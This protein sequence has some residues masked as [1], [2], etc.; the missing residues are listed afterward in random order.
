[1]GRSPEEIF[2]FTPITLVP[3]V[4]QGKVRSMAQTIKR[5]SLL[6]KTKVDYQLDQDGNPINDYAINHVQGCSHGCMYPCYAYL[7]AKRFG[8][9]GSYEEWCRPKLVENA[10]DLL[11]SELL[12]HAVHDNSDSV[13]TW[14]MCLRMSGPWRRATVE[15]AYQR[16]QMWE[17][18]NSV[19]ASKMLAARSCCKVDLSTPSIDRLVDTRLPMVAHAKGCMALSFI[20]GPTYEE[21]WQD[22][23]AIA[24]WVNQWFREND[25]G[26]SAKLLFK[27]PIRR[28]H[29]CVTADPFPYIREETKEE[30]RTYIDW[31][32]SAREEPMQPESLARLFELVDICDISIVLISRINRYGIPVT[33][34]TKGILPK[35]EQASGP[36]CNLSDPSKEFECDTILNSPGTKGLVVCDP[37]PEN[38]YG[39][40][41]VSLNERFREKWEPNTAPY[42][43]RIAALKALHDEGCKTWVSM[44]PFPALT[45]YGSAKLHGGYFFAP[46]KMP[47]EPSDTKFNDEENTVE[48]IQFKQELVDRY[49]T[50]EENESSRRSANPYDELLHVLEAVSFVDRIVFGRWNYSKDM[51]TDVND[52][53]AW[54]KNAAMI[55]RAFCAENNIECIIKKVV[56]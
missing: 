1:M 53:D 29:M 36:C 39:I 18:F 10:L 13:D 50:E 31:L 9:V 17:S 16:L 3:G 47:V 48:F 21:A 27:K 32:N 26:V 8:Q 12:E 28:V 49:S 2:E 44:E 5:K 56:D 19:L 51:P 24:V 7:M 43:K 40:S 30:G 41:L 11:D 25:A 35:F 52:V 14:R 37:H 23:M 6:Y 22:A 42:E 54:Y 34:L 4:S 15:S 20:S 45:R 38:Y 46:K 33:V 55:V